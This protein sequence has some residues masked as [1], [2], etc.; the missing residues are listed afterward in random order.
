[1]QAVAA[2]IDFETASACDLKACGVV[3][4]SKDPTTRVWCMAWRIGKGP[5]SLWTPFAPPPSALLE[6][7]RNGGRVIAHNDAFELYVWNNTLRRRYATDWPELHAEQLDC[8]MA[9]ALTLGLPGGLDQLGKVLGT[10]AQK[11]MAGSAVMRK[12][13]RPRAIYNQADKLFWTY[14]NNCEPLG[15]RHNPEWE[16]DE[17]R[18]EILRWWCGPEDVELGERLGDYCVGDVDAESEIDGV[19][20][21][22]TPAERELRLM[23]RL[24]NSRGVKIDRPFVQR[25]EALTE[26]V[27]KKANRSVALLTQGAVTKISEAGKLVTWLNGRGIECSSV[28][29]GELDDLTA[30]AAF[31]GD[32]VAETVLNLRVSS[33]KSSLAKYG[34]MNSSAL[35][36]D[37]RIR[38]MLQ[39]YGASTGRWAGRL[40]QP[41]NLIRLDAEKHL[42][43]VLL[44][45][46][47]V[48]DYG[49]QPQ[50]CYDLIE[51]FVGPVALWLSR[52]LRAAFCSAEGH[53]FVGGDFSNVEGRNNAWM[54]GEKWKCDA[55][56]AYDAGTGPDLYKLAYSKS[57]GCSIEAVDKPKRQ[58]GKVQELALG[59]QGS[60]GALVKM[61]AS[62]GIKARDL[63]GPVQS[64]TPPLVWKQVAAGYRSAQN[65][66]GLDEDA[67][68]AC[69]IVVNGWRGAHSAIVQSWWNLQDAVLEAVER[70]GITIQVK[71]YPV[72]FVYDGQILWAIL[73]NGRSLAYIR[74]KIKAT[75]Q[76]TLVMPDGQ[77]VPA[78]DVGPVETQMWLDCGA[79]I[80]QGKTRRQVVCEGRDAGKWTEYALYGGFLCENMVQAFC[81]DLMACAMF[82]A[83]A[84]GYPVVL[85]VHDELLTEPPL[86]FGSS[87]ELARIMSVLPDFA[88]RH[89]YFNEPM[90]LAAAAWEDVRYVK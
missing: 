64:A 59:Y 44:L 5:V 20:P 78:D 88:Q 81:R 27:K 63:I 69:K 26:L 60:V 34:R 65:K 74:P 53:W 57:F 50:Q 43:P 3:V 68:T 14:R 86:G 2:H 73:P 85:T 15:G 21:Q 4:Y 87:S 6:H 54:A 25:A 9:R 30:N 83:E 16:Y 40:V 61:S 28:S 90:P 80:V 31:L 10:T 55:F 35:A 82:R 12:M 1:M 39:F 72:R 77:E 23:D 76:D 67:W 48:H 17:A 58:I 84:N 22:L 49:H 75:R 13:M 8:T 33:G 51:Q 42:D 37:D 71:D 79:R 56:R 24:I 46:D 41:Q 29:K 89:P 52:A 70:R 47:L 66:A 7:I 45:I 32:D 38:E 36:E 18:G 11:D 19:L 62:N